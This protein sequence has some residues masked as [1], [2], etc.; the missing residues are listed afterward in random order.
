MSRSIRKNIS[1]RSQEY[2]IQRFDRDDGFFDDDDG[3]WVDAPETKTTVKVH[4]QPI[5]DKLND[6][7]PS[8]RQLASWHGWA[9]DVSGNKV[10]NKDII[11]I[12]DGLFTVSDL[13]HWPGDYRE[14]DLTRSGEAENIDDT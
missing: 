3:I 1:S 6:G 9:V 14:F 12:D 4:L 8:Q 10:S 5:V 13:V 11:T 2:K 7:V